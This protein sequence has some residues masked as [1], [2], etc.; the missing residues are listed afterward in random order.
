MKITSTEIT[1]KEFKKVMRGYSQEEVD[2]FL[3][4]V[5]EDY[6]VLYKE[7]S[8]LKEKVSAIDERLAHYNKMESTIQNTLL[9]AQNAAEHARENSQKEAELILRNADDSAHKIMDKA[10][11][12][13]ISVNDEFEKAKQ[14]FNKF[15]TK[16]RSFMQTHLEMFE[17]MEKDFVK[18]YNIGHKIDVKE[19]GLVLTEEDLNSNETDHSDIDEIKNFFVKE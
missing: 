4:R 8:T 10:Y 12:D 19:D 3:D 1:T 7:N 11:G 15:R 9:M 18:N 14:E 13:V 16:F 2:E 5:A 17:D 6:E